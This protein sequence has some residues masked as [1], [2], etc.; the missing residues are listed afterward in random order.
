M[1][2]DKENNPMDTEK[3]LNLIEIKKKEM[4]RVLIEEQ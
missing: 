4:L 3:I 1:R 2:E